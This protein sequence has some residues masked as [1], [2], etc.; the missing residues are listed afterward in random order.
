MN[1]KKEQTA[2]R[3]KYKRIDIMKN[4]CYITSRTKEVLK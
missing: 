2:G 4:E 1:N 3:K